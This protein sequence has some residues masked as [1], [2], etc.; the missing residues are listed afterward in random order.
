MPTAEKQ[1]IQEIQISNVNLPQR[2][3]RCDPTLPRCLPCERS[4]SI[5][6]YFDTTKGKKINRHYVVKLQDKVRAL[7]MELGQYTDEDDFPKN[8]ED[9]VRPG[10]LV[11][12]NETDETPRYLGPSSGIAMTRLLMEEAKRYTDSA[13]ISEL[14]PELRDR[15]RP[16]TL[17]QSSVD[18]RMSSFSVLP[19][20]A[21]RRKSY[22]MIS[23][24][25]AGE[26]PSRAISDKLIEVFYQRG[27]LRHGADV[28]LSSSPGDAPDLAAL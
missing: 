12:L 1:D 14:I 26:L 6:E 11:R 21:S 3:T 5:C 17:D 19:P 25:P 16:D 22:P 13:R 23:A 8:N 18:M 4:G 7:E 20:A 28:R 10:G 15:R 9:F 2:K 27:K 24:V